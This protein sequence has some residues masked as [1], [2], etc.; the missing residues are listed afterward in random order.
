MQDL[1][2]PSSKQVKRHLVEI[3]NFARFC[4]WHEGTANAT[5]EEYIDWT[6]QNEELQARLDE[7]RK[8]YEGACGVHDDRE[9]VRNLLEVIPIHMQTLPQSVQVVQCTCTP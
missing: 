8:D 3:V 4:E 5:Q 6:E 7:V 2:E 1:H 9:A